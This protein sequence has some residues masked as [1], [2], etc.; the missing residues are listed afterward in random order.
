MPDV[1]GHGW[2]DVQRLVPEAV[3]VH[4]IDVQL[5]DGAG[6]TA[7]HTVGLRLSPALR[8]LLPDRL[9]QLYRSPVSDNKYLY[10]S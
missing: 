4:L 1:P 5:V 9:G 2:H 8:L 7:A 6:A 3:G 10:F